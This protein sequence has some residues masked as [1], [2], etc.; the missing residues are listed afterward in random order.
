MVDRTR[1]V[2]IQ[3]PPAILQRTSS[4]LT[5]DDHELNDTG[6]KERSTTPEPEGANETII[7]DDAT[8]FHIQ[9]TP[10]D[11]PTGLL[12]KDAQ[13]Q[14]QD[15]SQS[16]AASE[17]QGSPVSTD[18]D[19]GP[20]TRL[21]IIQVELAWIKDRIEAEEHAWSQI[22]MTQPVLQA[23]ASALAPYYQRH[24]E[25]IALLDDAWQ[26]FMNIAQERYSRGMHMQRHH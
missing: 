16:P 23:R 12:R 3:S 4:H 13:E 15:A 8:I 2:R 26:V 17:W 7:R 14:R 6:A 9:G 21:H 11:P 24:G 20:T 22:P 19:I 10:T 1:R 25:L 18:T 5:I